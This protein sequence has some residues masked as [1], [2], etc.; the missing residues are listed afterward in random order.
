[1]KDAREPEAGRQRR[2]R[3]IRLARKELRET[4]RD[5]RTI[6]TLVLMPILVYPLLSLSFNRF[7]VPLAPGSDEAII[8]GVVP[9]RAVNMVD[10]LLSDGG[11][12]A[13]LLRE[14]DAAATELESRIRLQGVTNAARAVEQYRVAV[15]IEVENFQSSPTTRLV[16]RYRKGQPLS[17]TVLRFIERRLQRLNE[18]ALKRQLSRLG[19][20]AWQPLAMKPIGIEPPRST[21]QSLGMLLPLVLILMTI[22][23]AVYP[24]IDLTAGE[25]ERATLETLIAAPMPRHQLLLAKY[26]AVL[27]VALLTAVVN[28]TA[29]I[30]TLMVS[31]LG[32]LLFGDQVPS[33]ATVG[34]IFG[35]TILFATFFS[36]VLLAI[37]S[38]ARSFKEAQAYLIPLMLLAISPG[39][40]SMMPDLELHGALIVIPLV[41][42]VLLARDLLQGAASWDMTMIVVAS[43]ATYAVLAIAVAAR[44]FGTDVVGQA[45]EGSWGEWFGR[46]RMAARFPTS[47]QVAAGLA[48]A[49]ILFFVLGRLAALAD[50]DLASRLR[51]NVLVSVVVFAMMPACLAGWQRIR[52]RTTFALSMPSPAVWPAVVVLAVALWPMAHEL[53]LLGQWLAPLDNRLVAQVH[54]YVNELNRVPLAW[55]L[56][57]LAIVPAV[58]EEWFFRG[59]VMSGLDIERRPR[60]AV[61]WSALAF[62][63][64]HVLTPSM[65][66]PE[67]FLGT[68]FLGMVLAWIRWRSASLWP[69]MFVHIGHNSLLLIAVRHREYLERFVA[70]PGQVDL[71]HLKWPWIVASLAVSCTA[72]AWIGRRRG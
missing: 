70:E 38:F 8:V 21:T 40:L 42:I 1:M 58:V 34:M 48:L 56:L 45:A 9:G 11:R 66:L 15:A 67:R 50:V 25:R 52:W 28:L 36:A 44:V 43:T 60:H 31:G 71:P 14:N 27:T 49:F 16:L 64:F 32:G 59:F 30:V 6:V 57:T 2:G 72:L 68:T 47:N 33:L 29:M 4:L 55:V 35:L 13:R 37:T 19:K 3:W 54:A 7:L 18:N 69:G 39:I 65:L 41:N 24:A 26:V 22:T 10:R 46:P 17:L 53:V 12:I 63:V 23:G 62:G 51:L 20:T 61:L 5:R